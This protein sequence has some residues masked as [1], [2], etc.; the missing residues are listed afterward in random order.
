MLDADKVVAAGVE[1][2][3]PITLG[4]DELMASGLDPLG[5]EAEVCLRGA[6]ELG[7]ESAQVPP[8]FPLFV[9]DHL[10]ANGIELQVD[11]DA[12][13]SRRRV[14]SALELDGIRRAQKAA[15]AAMFVA[16]D[17]IH[18]LADGLTSED[19]RRAMQ[20]VCDDHGC[21]LPDDVIVSHG[22]QSA[23]G[24]DSGSG[25][26]GRGE[27]VVVDIWPRDRASRCWAD[28]TR[29]FVAGGGEPPA[30]LEEYWTLTRESLRRVYADLRAGA[31]GRA[32]YE[33]SCEPYIEAGRPTQL[34]KAPGTV[35]ED[36]Y[37]HGLGHGVGLEVHER[38][39][40][41]RLGDDLL[42]GDV[43][44]V[45]PGCYRR[46][47]GGCRLEDLVLVTDDGFELLTDFPYD[48]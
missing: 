10:R 3:D 17:L 44:T 14:K 2:I 48:L 4:Q 38:P 7:I 37:F 34:S 18:G 30:E 33:R 12:F 20:S 36:G 23:I 39:H 21:D 22:P 43:V 31:N 27:P 35:L 11:E 29:T 47:F 16:R 28:M 41:G 40:M 13:A 46:G 25:A 19:V 8:E 9:A 24:H 15:D 45:E 42:A 6:R 1:A 5:I 26:I 32:L